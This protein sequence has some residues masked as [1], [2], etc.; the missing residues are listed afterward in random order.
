MVQHIGSKFSLPKNI[1]LLALL[2]GE[3]EVF[4]SST[5]TRTGCEAV[6]LKC[7]PMSHSASPPLLPMP[8]SLFLFSLPPFIS[9]CT[10]ILWITYSGKNPWGNRI[11]CSEVQFLKST[12]MRISWNVKCESNRIINSRDLLIFRVW[13]IIHSQ[14]TVTSRHIIQHVHIILHS[15]SSTL[16]RYSVFFFFFF[17]DLICICASVKKKKKKTLKEPSGKPLLFCHD[18][19][20]KTETARQQRKPSHY[21][22]YSTYSMCLWP[23]E[24]LAVLTVVLSLSC[25]QTYK[26]NA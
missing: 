24:W 18:L 9:P 11:L 1:P 22:T 8:H 15:F 16:G 5:V 6:E 19:I 21:T 7:T 14:K 3:A 2:W 25:G 10:G 26:S 4:R 20:F 12:L 13:Q 23:I 17:L